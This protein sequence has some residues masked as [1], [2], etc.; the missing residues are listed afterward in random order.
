MAETGALAVGSPAVLS[1]SH[2]S[3]SPLIPV[4]VLPFKIN[5]F[6]DCRLKRY[7]RVLGRAK[8]NDVWNMIPILIFFKPC[9]N[10]NDE[11]STTLLCGE[12]RMYWVCCL[13]EQTLS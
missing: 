8:V 5:V 6:W 9:L 4:P 10:K 7:S 2:P 1:P 3:P 12:L 11:R 13:C